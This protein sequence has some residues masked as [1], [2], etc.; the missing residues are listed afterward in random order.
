MGTT[1][2]GPATR[3]VTPAQMWEALN[4]IAESAI[5]FFHINGAD[6]VDL[7]TATALRDTAREAIGWTEET[8]YVNPYATRSGGDL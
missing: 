8:N 5:P 7:R 4:E 1:G 3:S 2:D 6:C